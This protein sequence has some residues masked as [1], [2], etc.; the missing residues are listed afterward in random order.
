MYPHGEHPIKILYCYSVEQPMYVEIKNTL[1]QVIFNRGLPTREEIK[2]FADGNH[3]MI[4]LDDLM[5]KV[6][7]SDEILDMFILD[8]HHLNISV[9]Y[10][11]QNIFHQGKYCRTI[12]LNTQYMVLFKNPR[13]SSQIKNLARQ[14]YPMYPHALTEAYIDATSGVQYGYLF[15]DLTQQCKEELR[16]RAHITPDQY[17]VLYRPSR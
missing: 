2:S 5:T 4:I 1:P 17:T 9:I 7:K 10:M 14:I 15:I 8:S 11:V 3:N 13:D 12:A 16:M 6:Q